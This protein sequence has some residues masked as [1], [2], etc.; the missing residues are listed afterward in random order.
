MNVVEIRPEDFLAARGLS[1]EQL[2]D[3]IRT[4]AIRLHQK[5]AAGQYIGDEDLS[6][7]HALDMEARRRMAGS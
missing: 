5:G 4:Q 7:S 1:D 3:A 2:I 6:W